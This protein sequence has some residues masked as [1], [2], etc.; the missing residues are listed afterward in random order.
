M[1]VYKKWEKFCK[2]LYENK[3]QSTTAYGALKDKKE[4]FLILKHDVETNPQ[5]ALAMAKIENK[6]GHCG[7]YYVQAYLLESKEN[8][9]ILKKIKEL[10]HEVSY[11]HDVM[12]S[13]SGDLAK[14]L[15]EFETNKATFEKHGFNINTVCQHGNPVVQ[16]VGYT[17]NRDFFRSQQVK[18]KFNEIAEIM[19]DYREK[20][21][22]DFKYISDAGYGWKIIYDPETNDI[23]DSSD[24]DIKLKALDKVLDFI[25]N[26]NAVIL[27]T[28]PHRWNSNLVSA[29]IKNI[30]FKTIRFIAKVLKKIPIINKIMSKFYFLAKKI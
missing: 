15:E 2:N 24:K 13:N 18:E 21:G 11:H 25:K 23:V 22:V 29:V 8:I 30:I 4:N 26:E 19:V 27:S 17:S 20:I 28:H 3:I 1:F 7:V 14:A 12:D 6:Y 16:R 10:G 9:D 5:K